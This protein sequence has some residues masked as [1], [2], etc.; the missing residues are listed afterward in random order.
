[1]KEQQPDAIYSILFNDCD[2]K[3]IRQTKGQFG[4]HLKEHHQKA[5]FFCKKENS[6]LWEHTCLTYHTTGWDNSKIINT[7]QHCH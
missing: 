1:M 5:L 4:V 3:Y 6:A 7:N 2:H